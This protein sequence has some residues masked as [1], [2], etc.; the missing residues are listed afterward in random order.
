MTT[1]RQVLQYGVASTLGA[2]TLAQGASP[3]PLIAPGCH[4]VPS[5]GSR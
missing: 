5:I 1:R 2:A 3:V 4:G